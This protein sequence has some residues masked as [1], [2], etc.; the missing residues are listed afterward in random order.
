MKASMAL[1][2]GAA[3]LQNNSPIAAKSDSSSSSELE[4]RQI[5]NCT[6]MRVK[7]PLWA[8]DKAR[9]TWERETYEEVTKSK[10]DRACFSASHQLFKG[11]ATP[12]VSMEAFHV[13]KLIPYKKP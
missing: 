3:R 5:P 1:Q 6:C 2:N 4:F 11:D 7:K 12:P 9:K 8:E 13:F 10:K